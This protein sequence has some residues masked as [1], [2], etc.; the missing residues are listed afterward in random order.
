MLNGLLSETD[1]SSTMRLMSL[2]SLA[3]GGIIGLYGVYMGKDL[4]GTA[5]ICA[6][7]VTNAFGG[8]VIQKHME[9]RDKE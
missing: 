1:G 8:K 7:F 9:I 2:I 5:A 6:V 3:I 4:M